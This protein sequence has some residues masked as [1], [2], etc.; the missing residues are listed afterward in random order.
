MVTSHLSATLSQAV[1]S[2]RLASTQLAQM[3]AEIKR[4]ALQTLAIEISQSID[5]ILE[6]NQRDLDT[7]AAMVTAGELTES[8]YA[9]LRLNPNKLK[10]MVD[11]IEDVANLP[12]PIGQSVWVRELDQGL[13]LEKRTCPVGVLG[14]IFESRPDAVTQIASL[15]LKTGNSVLL[16]GGSE[17]FYSCHQLVQ[18]IHQALA[19]IPDFPLAAVQLLTSRE[20]IQ[21]L[22][23]L[24]KSVDLIIPRGSQAFVRYIQS[25]TRIPVLGHADGICHLF[26]DAQADLDMAV[27]IT[28]DAKV[29]Y[30]AACNAIE[31]LLVHEAIAP[32][33]LPLVSEALRTEQVELRGCEQTRQWIQIQ[34]AIETD[35]STE[36]G[37]RI[38]AIKTVPSL[39]QAL[40]HIQT[41][42][43]RHTEAIVTE[44]SQTAQLFLEQVDAAGV[45]HNASTRFADGYRYGFGA[46]VGI[47]TQKIP[48]R[49]PV[50]ID[51]LV[52]YKYHLR[53]QGHCVKDYTGPTARSFTHKDL[54][55]DR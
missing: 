2:S 52:T 14:V 10:T 54:T 51:G 21:A 27:Q 8:A 41:Y 49:G 35:W 17:A 15:A 47:S 19:T 48:P 6:A 24:E 4:Q 31:T 40:Q 26:V 34:P 1:H 55:A 43:S 5:P 33:F 46:E 39:Q 12:D 22:L 42:G 9:R 32:Q 37:D 30:P 29:Q 16:K 50:G 45:F 20:E 36:Y 28:V 53:G 13:I 18:V 11:S 23:D 7:A 25:N 44:H 38:L 3:S